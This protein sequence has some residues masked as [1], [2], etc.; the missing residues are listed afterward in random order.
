MLGIT[1]CE[2][3]KAKTSADAPEYIGE[4]SESPSNI[5]DTKNDAENPVRQAQLNADIR[6]REERNQVFG[7]EL[8]RA[9]ADLASEVR[10]KLEANIPGG[11]LTVE[12]EEGIVSV[13]G[14]VPDQ[15]KY[16]SIEPLAEEIKGV[17]QVLLDVEVVAPRVY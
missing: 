3:N 16:D 10:S 8:E 5:R 13:F 11:K 12:A 4:Q 7:E 15:K 14:T 2:N 1:A 17:K 9:D 6:A